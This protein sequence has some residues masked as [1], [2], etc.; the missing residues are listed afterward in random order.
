[1][2]ICI[3]LYLQNANK[4]YTLFF[5]ALKG[6]GEVFNAIPNFYVVRLLGRYANSNVDTI[7]QLLS[8][9]VDSSTD[10]LI[11]YEVTGRRP[12]GLLSQEAWNWLNARI[13][14]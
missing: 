13:S 3:S 12:N 9:Y 5:N 11:L 4:D 10:R 8:R 7:A 2:V 14:G 6:L 1:M